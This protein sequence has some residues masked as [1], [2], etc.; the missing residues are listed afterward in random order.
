MASVNIIA[1]TLIAL[2]IQDRRDKEKKT[3]PKYRSPEA[4]GSRFWIISFQNIISTKNIYKVSMS[5]PTL[6]TALLG[7]HSPELLT[8]LK[9]AGVETT[10][11]DSAIKLKEGDSQHV[12]VLVA[13]SDH[14][15]TDKTLLE[16]LVDAGTVLVA[17]SPGAEYLQALHDATKTPIDLTAIKPT[18]DRPLLT[19]KAGGQVH[20]IMP[21]KVKGLL[22]E[23]DSEKLTDV[24]VKVDDKGVFPTAEGIEA[25]I[26]AQPF[27]SS[28]VVKHILKAVEDVK[29]PHAPALAGEVFNLDPGND[30]AF[31]KTVKVRYPIL[32]EI[33]FVVWTSSGRYRVRTTDP[34]LVQKYYTEWNMMFYVYATNANPEGK[35]ASNYNGTIYTYVVHDGLHQRYNGAGRWC[36]PY[37]RPGS[38]QAAFYFIDIMRY[39]MVDTSGLLSRVSQLPDDNQ[40]TESNKNFNY[41]IS[42]EQNMTL[43]RANKKQTWNF[44]AQ[45]RKPVS[46]NRFQVHRDQQSIH[47]AGYYVT[48]NDYYDLWND[49]Q[50]STD[51]WWNP[52]VFD[53]GKDPHAV[54][55][56]PE[57]N[58]GIAGL[59]VF[60]STVGK[61]P[62]FFDFTYIPRAYKSN[63]WH[64]DSDDSYVSAIHL[65][66]NYN[67]PTD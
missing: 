23:V 8:A 30:V 41:E 58:L 33:R 53:W 50:F 42:R 62:L 19:Y 40:Y 38:S 52:G 32:I 61:A 67:N 65:D 7:E 64:T 4:R 29:M 45:Y 36:G 27:D 3:T 9:D 51:K 31:F 34:S 47:R 66:R 48:Y 18:A 10:T 2:R 49:P 55:I 43:Y 11:F 39:L 25:E 56:L 46:W 14:G 15:L 12:A 26:A 13:G 6:S 21:P 24:S 5:Q 59:T 17:F 60:S 63:S 44:N 16:S 37:S 28:E 57:D 1:G 22:K 20:L 35:T 54:K